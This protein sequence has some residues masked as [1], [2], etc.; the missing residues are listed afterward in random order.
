MLKL[1]PLEIDG[2]GEVAILPQPY[3]FYSRHTP[4][5]SCGGY[6]S[7][8]VPTGGIKTILSPPYKYVEPE[9]RASLETQRLGFCQ[10]LALLRLSEAWKL[11]L[12][13]DDRAYWLALSGK[14]MEVSTAGH[15]MM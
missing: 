12:V 8:Q 1:G 10:N 7:C 4:L 14:A 6:L 3:S 11:A 9:P 5:I 2:N 13:V 15:S